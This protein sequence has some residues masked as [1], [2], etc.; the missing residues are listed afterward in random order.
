M[1]ILLVTEKCGSS[2]NQ[3]DGGARLVETFKLAFGA[4]LNIM[5]FGSESDS[6]ARW[7]FKYPINLPNRFENRIANADF[8]AR[9]LKPVVQNFTHIIFVHISMQFGITKLFLPKKIS[10]WTFPMFLTPSYVASGESVP[11]KYTELERLALAYSKRILTPSYL[12]KKQLIEFYLVPEEYIRVI[13]RGVVTK[14]LAPKTRYLNYSPRFCG[15]GSIKPQKNTL[16]LIDLFAKINT[17]FLGSRLKI[18]GPV[19]DFEYFEKVL[20]KIDS[21]NLSKAVEFTG[22]VAPDNLA[23]AIADMH[24]HLS[25]SNCETFGRSIFETLASGLPNIA[26]ATA[27]AAADF[28]K[29]SP[30]IRFADNDDVVLEILEEILVNLPKLSS[31][32]LEIGEL[33]DDK[34]LSQLLVAEICNRDSMAVSDFDGTL[35]HTNSPE[36]TQKCIES[37]RR[38]STRIIC[39]ARP[40]HDLLDSLKYYN[41]TVDWIISYSGALVTDGNGKLLWLTPINSEE[42][43][44]LQQLVTNTKFIEFENNVLQIST[45]AESLPDIL[46]VRI[47]I[48][49][50]MAFIINWRASKLRAV[51]KLLRY[52]NWSGRVRV[53]GDGKYDNEIITFFDGTLIAS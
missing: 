21:L 10:V 27:N 26:K 35:F 15:V 16:G 41:L 39:S 48:Y 11:K 1:N 2:K 23:T 22:Y 25:T 31:M 33:Y 51:C 9:K 30:Y 28:L 46:G 53:F 43:S 6:S 5:Q 12:E 36:K 19:Q 44:N 52:I 7:H 45:P 17:E 13:P 47:E 34:M 40:L 14:F 37:F 32:A 8:I 3:R 4:S 24:V 29:Y 38:F 42:I 49:Q 18:I 50:G 20:A